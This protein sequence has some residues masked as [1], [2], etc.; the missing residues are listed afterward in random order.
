MGPNYQS[1]LYCCLDNTSPRPASTSTSAAASGRSI[2]RRRGRS[3]VTLLVS[4]KRTADLH[5][6]VT[7]PLRMCSHVTVHFHS[8]VKAPLKTCSRVTVD[9]HSQVSHLSGRACKCTVTFTLKSVTS[10]DVLA[11]APLTF[12]HKSPH[13]SGRACKCNV[14]FTLNSVTSQDVLASAPLTFLHKS[15]HV[16]GRAC[17]CTVTFTL[18][19]VTSLLSLSHSGQACHCGTS[20]FVAQSSCLCEPDTASWC[21][22]FC[23]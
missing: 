17:K 21:H 3:G 4:T 8:Q 23:A 9:L 10:H 15:P 16:S 14:T 20:L 5:L 18:K 2:P 13:L 1:H 12:L 22:G 11:S 6:Q 19:P 7:L